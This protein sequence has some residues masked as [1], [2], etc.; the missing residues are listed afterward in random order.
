MDS[1]SLVEY[2]LLKNMENKR[3][4][5]CRHYLRGDKKGTTDVFVDRLPGLPDNIRPN[6]KGGFYIVMSAPRIPSV[7]IF[8]LCIHIT[9][10][11][12]ENDFLNLFLN[13]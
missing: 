9:G 10:M 8:L 2:S 1:I 13:V 5:F 12:A 4:Q 3:S 6:G 7:I 11:Q